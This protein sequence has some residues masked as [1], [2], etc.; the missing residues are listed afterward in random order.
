MIQFFWGHEEDKTDR[1][2]NINPTMIGREYYHMDERYSFLDQG[3]DYYRTSAGYLHMTRPQPLALPS[4]SGRAGAHSQED[5]Q[6]DISNPS[7]YGAPPH[8]EPKS[9]RFRT[10]F[11]QEQKDKMLAFMVRIGWQI[12]KQ[13]EAV[14]LLFCDQTAIKL[15]DLNVWMHNNYWVYS[16]SVV[17]DVR[18]QYIG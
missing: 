3:H 7:S 16:T 1:N 17:N 4:T 15:H 6:D 12:Q 9:K 5:D 10:K 2:I 13:E 8:S 14:V 11:M 18:D